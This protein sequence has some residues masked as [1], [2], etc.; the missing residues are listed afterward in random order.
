VTK[1]VNIHIVRALRFCGDNTWNYQGILNPYNTLYYI[2]DGNGHIH[3]G[4]TIVDLQAGYV[5]LIPQ[6]L[7]QHV[8]CDSF[9]KKAYIDLHAEI[10]PGYDVFTNHKDIL[11]KHIGIAHCSH[12]YEICESNKIKDRLELQGE[13]A[14]T[15][16][17]FLTE[18][19]QP[20]SAKIVS[21]LPLITEMQQKPSARIRREE[22]AA[23]Y[24]WNVSVLS[25]TFKKVFGCGI[26][27][28][29]E[30]ILIARLTEELLLTDKT[31]Q[32]L[33]VEY[34]F[35]DAYYLSSFF[36]RHIGVSPTVYRHTH[37]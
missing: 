35:C 17:D 30:Q 8:W 2:L 22:L 32:C 9:I 3:Y 21:L 6:H 16:A 5:Y 7:T 37:G 25:R 20:F 14:L 36:K 15:L 26:K 28:Y 12:I 4:N 29:A 13:L 10:I 33:A 31:L 1:A 11:C 23:K 24:G 27:Q 19:P 34:G 18:E